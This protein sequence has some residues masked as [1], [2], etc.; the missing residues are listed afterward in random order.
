MKILPE[1]TSYNGDEMNEI[2]DALDVLG[3]SDGPEYIIDGDEEAEYGDQKNLLNPLIGYTVSASADG[4]HRH[5]GQMVDYTV[6]FKSPT[7]IETEVNTEMC[8]MVGWNMWGDTII[9]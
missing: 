7:G 4:D 1:G 2:F 6:I 5:D 8:L 3:H 9:K